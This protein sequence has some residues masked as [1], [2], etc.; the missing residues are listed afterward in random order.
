[1]S[2]QANNQ[3]TIQDLESAKTRLTNLISVLKEN[4]SLL[5]EEELK[6]LSG[7]Y[8]EVSGE[9]LAPVLDINLIAC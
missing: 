5:S 6:Q 3:K 1:M 7:G 4:P 8:S 2:T 9:E